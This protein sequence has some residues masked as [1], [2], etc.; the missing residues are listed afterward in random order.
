LPHTGA[1]RSPRPPAASL[2]TAQIFITIAPRALQQSC[3]PWKDLSNASNP[4]LI[5]APR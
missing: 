3:S 2:K 1:K 4:A 5:R